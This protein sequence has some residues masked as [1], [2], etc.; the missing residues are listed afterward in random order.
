MSLKSD[1]KTPEQ[2]LEKKQK[3]DRKVD[4][5]SDESFP[6]SDPPSYSGGK[7]IVGAPVERESD[8][9]GAD[10]PAV[11]KAEKK[12]KSGDAKTPETY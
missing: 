3:L 12:V 4:Q 8:S 6:A 2:K 10:H 11:K 5:Q 9:P 7:H 1:K